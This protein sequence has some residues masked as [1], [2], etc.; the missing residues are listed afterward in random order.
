[1]LVSL[2]SSSEATTFPPSSNVGFFLDG[3]WV[4]EKGGL[5]V[6]V[7]SVQARYGY[8]YRE[9]WLLPPTLLRPRV[10]RAQKIIRPHPLLLIAEL[11]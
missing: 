8:F 5:A 7:L 3:G 10:A 1:V 6:A 9:A 2:R 4:S 11:R